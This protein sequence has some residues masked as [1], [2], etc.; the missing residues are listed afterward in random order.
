MAANGRVGDS[1]KVIGAFE[2][3]KYFFTHPFFF[4]KS[5]IRIAPFGW[6]ITELMQASRGAVKVTII[7][8][9]SLKKKQLDTIQSGIMNMIGASTSVRV[10]IESIQTPLCGSMRV[11]HGI[12]CRRV[13]E[14]MKSCLVMEW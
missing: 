4:D 6:S 14:M 11:C 2:G 10:D 13:L 5:F 7:S 3:K 8:A 1:V 12:F 9:E